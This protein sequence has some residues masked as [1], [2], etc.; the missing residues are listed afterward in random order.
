MNYYVIYISIGG[1]YLYT[2]YTK[3]VVAIA[4]PTEIKPE[5]EQIEHKRPKSRRKAAKINPRHEDCIE[6]INK[7]LSNG[8]ICKKLGIKPN[9]LYYVKRRYADRIGPPEAIDIVANSTKYDSNIVSIYK[10]IAIRVGNTITDADIKRMSV[11][12][13]VTCMA[14][15]TDKSRLIEGKSTENQAV[16]IMHN[17]NPEDREVLKE[18]IKRLKKSMLS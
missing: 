17:L 10:D 6:L 16:Q 2:N 12:Q 1:R 5:L 15:C 13:R 18:A 11:A 14:V 9:V 7:G 4:M 8:V 3:G